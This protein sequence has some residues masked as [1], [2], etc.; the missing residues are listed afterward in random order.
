VVALYHEK[1]AIHRDLLRFHHRIAASK[2]CP[3]RVLHEYHFAVAQ[4]VRI[5]DDPRR[6]DPDRCDRGIAFGRDAALL[7]PLGDIFLN[8]LFTAIIPVVFFSISSAVAGMS[9]VKRLGNLVAMMLV[10][11]STGLVAS[12]VM[13]RACSSTSRSRGSDPLG[14]RCEYEPL[15]GIRADR[16]STHR[17]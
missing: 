1:R 6:I 3:R 12:A 14:F 15:H 5:F 11:F 7:K 10:F 8:L 2:T 13:W 9:N 4:V 16:Q 17:R